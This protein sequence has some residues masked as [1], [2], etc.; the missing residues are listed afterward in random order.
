MSAGE[1]TGGE[2][3]AFWLGSGRV[4]AGMTINT[5]DRIDSITA[6]ITPAT[7]SPRIDV[8]IQGFRCNRSSRAELTTANAIADAPP[9]G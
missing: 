2:F 7:R 9:S 1:I 4:L 3:L 5:W 6:G 8:P